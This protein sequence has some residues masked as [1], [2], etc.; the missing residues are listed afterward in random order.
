MYIDV[1]Y[2]NNRPFYCQSCTK[3]ER[4]SEDVKELLLNNDAENLTQIPMGEFIE[5]QARA[6]DRAADRARSPASPKRVYSPLT[7]LAAAR[8]FAMT[9]QTRRS[10]ARPSRYASS[11]R[12]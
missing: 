5:E 2:K 4:L 12:S 8:R 3:Y 9:L 11:L 10:R 7:R 6:R 1:Q